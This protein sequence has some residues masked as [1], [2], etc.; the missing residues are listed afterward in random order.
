[1]PTRNSYS[2]SHS[3]V[4]L[5]S[6]ESPSLV[7]M[8]THI[9]TKCGC[10]KIGRKCHL[11]MRPAN[12]TNNSMWNAIQ[13]AK[14]NIQSSK[15][16][17]SWTI[18]KC[19]NRDRTWNFNFSKTVTPLKSFSNLFPR[20]P[21]QFS[22]VHHLTLHFPSNF[23]EDNTRIYYIGL[24]GEFSQAHYHGV[25][26]CNYESRPNVSDHKN[27]VFDSVNHSVQ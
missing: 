9:Q 8:I 10:S 7:P 13:M 5:N 21:V 18:S 17:I 4:I 12:R 22:S 1:M 27:D 25:T 15:W 3:P 2:T 19:L 14:L 23:G 11:M 20:R 26:I 6:K 24:R 16:K